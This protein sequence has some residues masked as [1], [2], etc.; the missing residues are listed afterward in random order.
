MKAERF[1]Q[2]RNLFEAALERTPEAR[3]QFIR[4][5]CHGDEELLMEVGR[6]LM[7]QGQSADWIDEG[8]LGPQM[9]RLE[10]R[11][12]GPYDILRQL[13]EGGMGAVYLAARADGAFRKTLALKIVRPA[14]ANPEVLRRFQREREVLAMLD[15]PNIARIVD[16]GETEDGLPYLVM[17][18]V[19]GEPI[20]VYCDRHRLNVR[21]RL[22]L[23]RQVCAAVQYSHQQ[24]V[25][26]RDLKPS[27]ILVTADGTVKLL[28]FGIAKL[29]AGELDGATALTVPGMYLMTPEYSSPEQVEGGPVSAA[30]DVY[31]LGVVLYELLTG[32]RPNRM[33]SRIIHEVVRV[34]REEAPTRPSTVLGQAEDEAARTE[35]EV[36]SLARAVSIE[37]LKRELE[38]D[39]DSILLKALSKDASERY[40]DAG[41]LAQELRQHLEG[42]EIAAREG[43]FQRSI[44][45]FFRRSTWLL[46]AGVAVILAVNNG[47]FA[48]PP[49]F[50]FSLFGLFLVT[51]Y[52]AIRRRLGAGFVA[53]A[54]PGLAKG[55]AVAVLT[56]SA[57]YSLLLEVSHSRR[58]AF[59][60]IYL[61]GI[62]LLNGYVY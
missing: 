28:D 18:Y 25:V 22:A 60:G 42:G 39:L 58:T 4:E 55:F 2:I 61:L 40:P 48:G 31:A 16:G 30:T 5:A 52:F 38:G 19:E 6:L 45:D 57:T 54:L 3:S 47:V 10:G 59:F 20:D 13:G 9:P 56:L 33:R 46:L 43:E 29:G 44:G 34:I 12:I 49:A 1:R 23:F 27:N 11:R 7:A 62:V 37:E 21:A 15:H 17:D 51:L 8:V 32:R 41:S 35:L 14:A 36:I 53:E 26:H 50:M 24:R